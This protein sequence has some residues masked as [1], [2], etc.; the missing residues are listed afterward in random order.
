MN[1]NKF[2]L[3]LAPFV[4]AITLQGYFILKLKH[5]LDIRKLVNEQTIMQVLDRKFE[6]TSNIESQTAY[7]YEQPLDEPD[8]FNDHSEV[9]ERIEM[10]EMH[11][12]Y[13]P[14]KKWIKNVLHYAKTKF[15]T[16]DD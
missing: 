5:D 9:V 11:L 1:K 10:L 7:Q 12:D 2:A 6:H 16:N 3:M 15:R 4:V 13:N 14:S 8:C